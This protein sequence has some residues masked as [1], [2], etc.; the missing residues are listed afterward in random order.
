MARR[1]FQRTVVSSPLAV[2]AALALAGIAPPVA[3]Q[4]DPGAGGVII[5][6]RDVPTRHAFLP[7]TGEA[8]VVRTAPDMRVFSALGISGQPMSDDEAAN[9]AA[10]TGQFETNNFYLQDS[11]NHVVNTLRQT[12][13]QFAESGAS[14]GGLGGS[15]AST[16]STGM[17]GLQGG[18]SALRSVLGAG[19]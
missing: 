6:G 12:T 14:G 13:G 16:I 15:I 11:G 10:A 7:G 9:V 18:L 1:Y 17:S 19:N 8:T 5:I 2:A 4:N 3:A